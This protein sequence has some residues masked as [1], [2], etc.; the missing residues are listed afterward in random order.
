M[1]RVI[2]TIAFEP[3]NSQS[4]E[5]AETEIKESFQQITAS[6]RNQVNNVVGSIKFEDV[7][8]L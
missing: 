6:L 3:T 1:R 7:E 4:Q 2:A 5:L 8:N